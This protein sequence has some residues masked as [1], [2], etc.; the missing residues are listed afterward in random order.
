MGKFAAGEFD[1]GEFSEGDFGKGKFSKGKF[2][3]YYKKQFHF[4]TN[5]SVNIKIN[6][7]SL[8]LSFYIFVDTQKPYKAW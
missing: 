6:A 1:K 5:D 7:N 4:S 8:L 3:Q 2:F